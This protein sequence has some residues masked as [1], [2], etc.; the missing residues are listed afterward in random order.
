MAVA[1]LVSI[2]VALVAALSVLIRRR[3]AGVG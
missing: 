3:R 1:T 2:G